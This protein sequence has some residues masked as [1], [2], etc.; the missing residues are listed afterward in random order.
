MKKMLQIKSLWVLRDLT[1]VLSELK[2][3]LN[4]PPY[5]LCPFHTVSHF[6]VSQSWQHHHRDL[7]KIDIKKR[8]NSPFGAV[9]DFLCWARSLGLWVTALKV[10]GRHKRNITR[11]NIPPDPAEKQLADTSYQGG[12]VLYKYGK[13]CLIVWFTAPVMTRKFSWSLGS[14]RFPH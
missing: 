10:P 9:W 12:N 7:S 4:F 13:M 5:D 6:S 3:E 8:S 11:L 1:C 14:T 2:K